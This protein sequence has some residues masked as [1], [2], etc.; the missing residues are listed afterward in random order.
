MVVEVTAQQVLGPEGGTTLRVDDESDSIRE[1]SLLSSTEI[2]LRLEDSNVLKAK[3][4]YPE[5]KHD[6]TNIH[7]KKS[8][9]VNYLVRKKTTN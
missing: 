3:I 7:D 4:T 6:N 1:H 5:I 8:T 2:L 9:V